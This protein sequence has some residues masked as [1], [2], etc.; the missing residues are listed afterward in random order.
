MPKHEPLSPC[1][2]IP[3]TVTYVEK[4]LLHIIILCTIP[5]NI[6]NLNV[7]VLLLSLVHER[8]PIY[9]SPHPFTSPSLFSTTTTYPPYH[10]TKSA[11]S[12]R[13]F[14]IMTKGINFSGYRFLG[15]L[16]LAIVISD[17][18]TTDRLVRLTTSEEAIGSIR[19]SAVETSSG[20][21][22]HTLKVI[23]R[24][25]SQQ[26]AKILK[27][28]SA[29][30]V[31]S[32]HRPVYELLGQGQGLLRKVFGLEEWPDYSYS[33]FVDHFPLRTDEGAIHIVILFDREHANV[34]DP[35]IG[36]V[37]S[38]LEHS[39]KPIALH[40]GTKH[41]TIPWLDKLDSPF[42]Q[43]NFYNPE[44][45]GYLGN[46]IRLQKATHFNDAHYSAPFT[47]VKPFLT[48]LPFPGEDSRMI[49]HILFLDDDIM[50]WDD[51]AKMMAQLDPD[52]IALSCPED[53]IRVK[54]NSI[55][56]K[57]FNNGHDKRY[58]NSGMIHF[59][60]YPRK[61]H[62][63]YRYSNSFLDTYIQT[64]M[65]M[66]NDYPGQVYKV[67]EQVMYNRLFRFHEDE[68]GNIPC[69]WH[70][71]FA[72]LE[73]TYKKDKGVKTVIDLNFTDAFRF[74]NCPEVGKIGEDG[75]KTQCRAFHLTRGAYRLENLTLDKDEHS[76][77]VYAGR[78]SL[79]LIYERFVSAFLEV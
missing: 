68:M 34:Q 21:D 29:E 8:D 46:A 24:I 49:K 74:M 6:P 17:F 47:L 66:H 25:D 4:L 9:T 43:I 36:T 70:C 75:T 60:I 44:K 19:G 16:F 23:T 71:D 51:P 27:T 62:P 78:D 59:P 73:D 30:K 64:A 72:T 3:F 38:L 67:S 37:N 5:Y 54:R 1:V 41:A 53:W 39:T 40:V 52:K 14:A 13:Y 45:L 79:R 22:I 18:S 77:Q 2:A 31:S 15:L 61:P 76:Y 35:L 48:T 11:P 20:S 10:R 26:I 28:A 12:P 63:L 57:T 58:C 69:E 50:F 42:F 7:M 65:D 56:P 55:K 33:R 32:A